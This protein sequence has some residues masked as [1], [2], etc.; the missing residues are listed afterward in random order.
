MMNS[1]LKCL[2]CATL[3]VALVSSKSLAQEQRE[4]YITVDGRNPLTF[5]TYTGLEN[6][7]LGRLTLLFA[8][9]NQEMP[10]NNHFHSIGS[11]SYEGPVESPTV[12]TTNTNN[13]IPESYTGQAPVTLQEGTDS[14]AGKLVSSKTD[15]H[16][17][18]LTFLSI[19][20]LKPA[21]E[22]TPEG[23]MYASSGGGYSSTTM[24]GMN[25][26]I[27]IVAMSPGLFL[28]TEQLSAPGER[29]TIGGES[30]LPYSPVFWTEGDAA[31][32]HYSA[33]FK[34]VDLSGTF[35]D[36]GTINFDFAVVPEPCSSSLLLF[37]VAAAGIALRRRGR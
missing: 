7:N 25:L 9:W 6:P 37:G 8:H 22:G 34:L 28:G 35:P 11:Y 29:L 26:A 4:F 10:E 23:I 1:L 30:D 3:T 2:C 27:E 13:R 15:E 33:E 31:P 16:Y 21:A 12:T 20:D 18:D 5:G 36:S 19:H 14:L 24:D 32:G 17:S